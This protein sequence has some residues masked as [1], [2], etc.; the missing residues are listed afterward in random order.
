MMLIFN[1]LFSLLILL[2][3]NQ[4]NS[5]APPKKAP[6]KYKKLS[7][8][9]LDNHPHQL[10]EKEE[11]IVADY[12]NLY[13]D[14]QWV[15]TFWINYDDLRNDDGSKLSKSQRTAIIKYLKKN[16]EHATDKVF[17]FANNNYEVLGFAKGK[18]P[19]WKLMHNYLRRLVCL[20][21]RLK[22]IG[23][24]PC[25]ANKQQLALSKPPPKKSDL[26]QLNKHLLHLQKDLSALIAV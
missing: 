22:K 24:G 21:D 23:S 12:E 8:F 15:D 16:S 19:V 9:I 17:R 13:L 5:S 3:C 18:N 2:V 10:S 4:I 6:K 20:I 7:E 11:G 1:A 26:N 14:K 25:P